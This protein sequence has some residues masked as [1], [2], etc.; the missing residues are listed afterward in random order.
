MHLFKSMLMLMVLILSLGAQNFGRVEAPGMEEEE[1]DPIQTIEQ[2][3]EWLALENTVDPKT[4]TLGAGDELGINILS[5]KVLT[6]LLTVTP[7]GDLF[8]PGVGVCHVAGLTLFEAIPKVQIFVKEQAF[9]GAQTHL[10]LLSPRHF[11]LLITGA[12]NKPGFVIVSPLTRLDEAIEQVDGFHQLAKEYAIEVTKINGFSETVNFHQYLLLGELGSNPTFI[13]GDE[14]RVPF[15]NI[16]QNGIVVRGSITGAGYDI[17]SDNETL[18][19]YIKRH[20]IFES[21][22]DLQNVTISR[23]T[24]S[25]TNHIVIP[26]AE[27]DETVLLPKDEINFMWERGVMVTGF[28]QSPGGFTYFPGYSVTDY[29]ALAG[30]NTSDGNPRAV[31][32]S[33]LNSTIQKGLKTQV[34]RGDVIYVPRTRKDIY[35]GDMSILSVITA[36]LTVYLT[37]LSATK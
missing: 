12:V 7:T 25:I 18:G 17:I 14:V 1:D 11:K 20:V 22:S 29:I 15:G 6:F 26:P 27:F 33:H 2:S 9:P 23:T 19:D 3:A 34:L 36:L 30:G 5:N 16:D 13:E 8:I 37:F 31:S 4:Y 35:I 21:N 24:K 32:I 28:V 10:A